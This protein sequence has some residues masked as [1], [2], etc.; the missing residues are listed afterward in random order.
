METK[1]N[2]SFTVPGT[3]AAP[4]QPSVPPLPVEKPD[5]K[6]VTK[7]VIKSDDQSTGSL[8]L[9][10]IFLFLVIVGLAGF[11]VLHFVTTSHEQAENDSSL[12]GVSSEISEDDSTTVELETSVLSRSEIG[13]VQSVVASVRSEIEK[14]LDDKYP[15][16][17]VY[18][19]YLLSFRPEGYETGVPLTHTYGVQLDYQMTPQGS[20]KYNELDNSE[21]LKDNGL[22]NLISA[23]L[24]RQ[25][26]TDTGESYTTASAGVP[27][28]IFE[29]ESTGVV[30]GVSNWVSFDCGYKTWYDRADAELSNALLKVYN[31][32]NKDDRTAD[33]VVASVKSI[34]EGATSPT[35]TLSVGMTG[36]VAMFYRDAP[37]AE[38]HFVYRGQ[39]GPL[40]SDFGTEGAKKAYAGT[41]CWVENDGQYTESTVRL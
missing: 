26:F 7:P 6:P 5:S 27:P 37:D 28:T 1:S 36:T 3:A 23:V 22:F 10:I 8:K 34:K 30:C 14:A 39:G 33:Y 20:D 38:W 31:T 24:I 15:L 17:N 19:S 25:G 29:N 4:A 40:C 9:I 35:Q 13:A 18:D 16:I 41:T 12:G 21:L 2:S 32:E 11:V